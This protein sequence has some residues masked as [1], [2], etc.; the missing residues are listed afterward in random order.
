MSLC[1]F[2]VCV[3]PPTSRDGD[4]P[5][6]LNNLPLLINNPPLLTNNLPLLI[7]NPPLS[8]RV[9]RG[10]FLPQFVESGECPIHAH[11]CGDE[12][13]ELPDENE[14]R[15]VNDAHGRHPKRRDAD[16][17]CHDG[18]PDCDDFL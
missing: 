11:Q 18:E 17:G 16:D 5:L 9:R 2:C 10:T 14:H 13:Q 3:V 4:V 8:G 15:L 12:E 1:L 7:N 6:F